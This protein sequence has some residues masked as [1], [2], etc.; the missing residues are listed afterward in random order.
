[1]SQIFWCG[2]FLKFGFGKLDQD[3]YIKCNEC[4]MKE[5]AS[6]TQAETPSSVFLY[7]FFLNAIVVSVHQKP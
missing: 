3:Y 4:L 6:N 5:L 2:P 1:M 7:I